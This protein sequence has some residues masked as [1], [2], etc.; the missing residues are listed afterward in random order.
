MLAK[1]RRQRKGNLHTDRR[2]LAAFAIVLFALAAGG[3]AYASI[4]D[5]SGVIH[6]CYEKKDGTLRVIDTGSGGSCSAKKENPLDWN[7]KGPRGAPGP[8]GPTG[9]QGA[10]ATNLWALVGLGPMSEF[11]RLIRSSG[12]VT[13]SA[14]EDCSFSGRDC[15]DQVVTF[16]RDVSECVALATDSIGTGQKGPPFDT[17]ETSVSGSTVTVFT[18]SNVIVGYALAVFC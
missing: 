7:Q 10:P 8:T 3:I 5:G 14:V 13:L 4:P 12:G 15:V 6:G 17:F 11:D 16:P 9:P 1:V 2:R 18:A